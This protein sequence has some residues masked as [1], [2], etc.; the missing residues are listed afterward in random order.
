M[1]RK[2]KI[3]VLAGDGIGKE[4]IPEAVRILK[5]CEELIGGF[6]LDFHEFEC[7]GENYLKTNREWSEEA[8]RFTKAE[9]D[10]VLLGAIGAKDSHGQPVRLPD[11]N[12]A[13]YN[14]VIGLRME[15]DLYANVRPIKLFDG[16]PTPLALETNSIDM[17]IIRENTEGLYTPTRGSLTR[18]GLSEVAI[19]TRVI[20][21]K[22]SERVAKYAFK[23]SE[24]RN[25]APIDGKKRVTCVDKSNLL[26]GCRLFRESFDEV[27][28]NY[29]NVEKDYAYVDAF[30]QWLIRKPEYY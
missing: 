27:A 5:T 3:S 22:G 25:G 24:A 4:V 29:P 14:I 9:A 13:G 10:A 7:G 12:L 20:T 28:K 11:H 8:E 6:S 1:A 17:V 18:G 23:T 26:A 2:Y 21:Q 15:L 19:D 16:V 30:A